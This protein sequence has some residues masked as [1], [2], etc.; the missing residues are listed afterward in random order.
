MAIVSLLKGATSPS[1][2]SCA[3]WTVVLYWSSKSID[4]GVGSDSLY[5]KETCIEKH[6]YSS[7]D[8]SSYGS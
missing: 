3:E 4:G 5:Y 7:K 6:F 1:C 2:S 8:L